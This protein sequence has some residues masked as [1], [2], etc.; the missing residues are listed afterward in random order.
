MIK[1]HLF[2]MFLLWGIMTCVPAAAQNTML[3]K[4]NVQLFNKVDTTVITD[5]ERVGYGIFENK[6]RAEAVQRE[7]QRIEERY[8]DDFVVMDEKYIELLKREN[9][10]SW[11]S[12]KTRIFEANVLPGMAILF[13]SSDYTTTILEIQE[14]VTEYKDIT[15]KVN[16][17]KETVKIGT[18]KEK[19]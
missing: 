6:E 18:P 4:G 7:F 2:A 12:A 10:K 16:R 15:L 17:L 8:N 3:V 11:T 9:I 14:G 19:R 5:N 1:K 13:V